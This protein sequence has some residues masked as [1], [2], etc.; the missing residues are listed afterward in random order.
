MLFNLAEGKETLLMTRLDKC[1]AMIYRFKHNHSI[2]PEWHLLCVGRSTPPYAYC[3]PE[4]VDKIHNE[5]NKHRK[6]LQYLGQKLEVLP[7]RQYYLQ[8]QPDWIACI[9]AKS[10]QAE[11][12]AGHSLLYLKARAIKMGVKNGLFVTITWL[13][14]A[15][16]WSA[17]KDLKA[18][19]YD[20]VKRRFLRS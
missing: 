17:F 10:I 20:Y 9:M 2:Q 16:G 6:I 7:E 12:I 19:F 8:G 5:E 11:V 18:L 15:Y 14:N 13:D 1:Q 4:I 3:L